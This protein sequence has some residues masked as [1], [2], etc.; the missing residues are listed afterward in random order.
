[1]QKVHKG[2]R[3]RMTVALA[4]AAIGDAVTLGTSNATLTTVRVVLSSWGCT[5]G[6]WFNPVGGRTH[7]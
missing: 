3:I 1:M 5:S 4:G 6:H 7:A 2:F